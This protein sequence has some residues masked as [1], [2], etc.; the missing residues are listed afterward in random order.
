MDK[1]IASLKTNTLGLV[2]VAVLVSQVYLAHIRLDDVFTRIETNTMVRRLM[3][4][5]IGSDA[6]IDEDALIE[7][8]SQERIDRWTNG[9]EDIEYP[10]GVVAEH[11]HEMPLSDKLD[12]PGTAI[13]PDGTVFHFALLKPGIAREQLYKR[14]QS[15]PNAREFADW[16]ESS[17]FRMYRDKSQQARFVVFGRTGYHGDSIVPINQRD[18]TRSYRAAIIGD[19]VSI[20][21]LTELESA[22]R[23]DAQE[24]GV[25]TT[26]PEEAFRQAEVKFRN[27][28]IKIPVLN[29]EVAYLPAMFFLLAVAGAYLFAAASH[30]RYIALS[31]EDAFSEPWLPGEYRSEGNALDRVVQWLARAAATLYVVFAILSATGVATAAYLSARDS[32]RYHRGSVVALTLIMLVSIDA[33]VSFARFR[34]RAMKSYRER[35]ARQSEPPDVSGWIGA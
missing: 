20:F 15:L 35:L 31:R 12:I 1:R 10:T 6:I 32:G 27:E 13:L 28:R 8:L 17:I 2:I 23:I 4:S 26:D 22:I 30:L 14:W 5:E 18:F 33:L 25:A 3:T 19:D 7:P 16:D 34:W 11:L 9:Q 24:F 29:I 21:R